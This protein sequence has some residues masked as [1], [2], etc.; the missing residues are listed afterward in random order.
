MRYVNSFHR[1]QADE[2]A[3]DP[4]AA[5]PRE[6]LLAVAASFV[7]EY[8]L[9][10]EPADLLGRGLEFP[11]SL[12]SVR[13]SLQEAAD[14]TPYFLFKMYDAYGVGQSVSVSR[15]AGPS[16]MPLDEFASRVQ[17]GAER[18]GRFRVSRT[19]AGRGSVG[20]HVEVG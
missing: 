8:D 4:E 16:E 2:P 15:D 19:A 1:K 20:S 10:V 5:A 3:I 7:A 14:G 18:T 13:Y 17:H 6:R 12:G 9:P 11:E